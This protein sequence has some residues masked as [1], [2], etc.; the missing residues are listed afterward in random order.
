MEGALSLKLFEMTSSSKR[1]AGRHAL[2]EG[3]GAGAMHTGTVML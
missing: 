1:S 3:G 2:D